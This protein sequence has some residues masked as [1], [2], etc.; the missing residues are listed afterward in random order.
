ML[1]LATPVSHPAAPRSEYKALQ[2]RARHGRSPDLAPSSFRRSAAPEH[3]RRWGN[4]GARRARP[5]VEGWWSVETEAADDV[6][7]GRRQ[8]PADFQPVECIQ[9]FERRPE[10]AVTQPPLTFMVLLRPP[11]E[12]LGQPEELA[13]SADGDRLDR[14]RLA[15]S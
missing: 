9:T 8:V 13:R 14:Q 6:P 3:V 15:A 1:A 12:G 7:A 4:D 11:A 10:V 2:A 5:P